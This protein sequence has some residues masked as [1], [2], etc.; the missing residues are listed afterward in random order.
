MHNFILLCS[1]KIYYTKNSIG[2]SIF[3]SFLNLYASLTNHLRNNI[4]IILCSGFFIFRFLFS[5]NMEMAKLYIIQH[6]LYE[7]LEY[8]FILFCTINN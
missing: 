5:V 1:L 6:L 8:V 4:R 3:L 7:L 2:D